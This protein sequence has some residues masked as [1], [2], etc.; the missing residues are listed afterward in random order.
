MKE[1]TINIQNEAVISGTGEHYNGNCKPVVCVDNGMV[2]SSVIDAA[3]YAKSTVSLMSNTCRGY[4]KTC[5]GKRYCFLNKALE[6]LDPVMER[7]REASGYE[8]DAMK[9]RA[10][11]A[12]KEEK[13]RLER[14]RYNKIKKNNERIEVLVARKE[15]LQ[16]RILKI[17]AEIFEL[18]GKNKELEG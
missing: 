16:E 10:I 13:E 1:N 14:E 5:K 17:N 18:E 3:K 8:E 15:I 9:Y 4:G 7:L 6:Q 12:E 11:V 2:F